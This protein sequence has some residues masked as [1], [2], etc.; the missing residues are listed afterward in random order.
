V[1]IGRQLKNEI[2]EAIKTSSFPA[3]AFS[4][5][6]NESKIVLIHR[7]SESKFELR[8]EGTDFRG[9]WTIAEEKPA[10]AGANTP[11]PLVTRWLRELEVV[12]QTPDL[13]AELFG[14]SDAVAGPAEDDP[15]TPFDAS[16]Q[17]EIAAWAAD[18]EANA[19]EC[20]DLND[21][22]MKTLVGTLRELVEASG[23]MG[24]KD[25]YNAA[26]GSIVGIVMNRVV[27]APVAQQVLESM[28]SVLG[29]LFGHPIPQ[30]GSGP[31]F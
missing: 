27:E 23:R 5:E 11:G 24:R 6:E 28:V 19:A 30:L 29:H 15:N 20:Y 17:A 4:F 26:L 13:W 31:L 16:E 1:L 2:A 22:Q 25:W 9:D 3:D 14:A 18:L 7:P 21:E 10:V 8:E 12:L